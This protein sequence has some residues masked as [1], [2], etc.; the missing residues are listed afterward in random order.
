[1]KKISIFFVFVIL[2]LVGF[3]E[4]KRPFKFSGETNFFHE[5]ESNLST[6]LSTEY[7]YVL[8]ETHKYVF[9]FGGKVIWD[10]DHFGN[11]L[12]TNTFTTFGVD[13]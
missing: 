10:Y 11:Q 1:M 9:Y 7:R 4:E 12:K 5:K 6:S 3:S 2:P 13:F 8:K